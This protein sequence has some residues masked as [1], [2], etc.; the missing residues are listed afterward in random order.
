MYIFYAR[1]RGYGHQR[2][3][4]YYILFSTNSKY[5]GPLTSGRINLAWIALK[6]ARASVLLSNW[7]KQ[8]DFPAIIN[9]R[10]S[11]NWENISTIFSRRIPETRPALQTMRNCQNK[12]QVIKRDTQTGVFVRPR[13]I[14]ARIYVVFILQART[15]DAVTWFMSNSL[16]RRWEY[17]FILRDNLVAYELLIVVYV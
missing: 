2:T 7:T 6:A 14:G 12:G 8:Q 4:S 1:T 17:F 3:N 16:W 10:R 5:N 15:S 11:E 9:T 13:Y